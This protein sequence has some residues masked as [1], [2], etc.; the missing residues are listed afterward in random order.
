MTPPLR[1]PMPCGRQALPRGGNRIS[2]RA[3]PRAWWRTS[4]RSSRC[5]RRCRFTPAVSACSRA[6]TARK[7]ATSGS[8]SS[9][10]DSCTRRVIS[11]SASLPRAGSRRTTNTSTGTR[12]RLS[13]PKPSTASLAWCSCRWRIDRCSCRSG[14][15]G[16][17]ACACCCSTRISSRTRLGIASCPRGSTAGAAKRAFSRKSCSASV[18]CSR[19]ARSVSTP[20]VWHLNEGHAAFVILQRLRDLLASG[21][22]WEDALAEVRRTT[23]FTTH[24]PVPAGHDAF[25]FHMVEQHLSSSWGSMNGHGERFLALGHHDSGSGAAFNMT[26]LAMRSAGAINA[27]SKL[28]GSVTRDMFAPLWPDVD[29][30]DRPVRAITNGVHVPT[31]VAAD[32]AALFERHLSP[33]WREQYED[34][35]FWSRIL[36]IP[37]EEIWEV[38]G[39]LRAHLFQFIRERARQRWTNDQAGAARVVASGAMLDPTALTIGFARRFTGYKRPDLVFRDIDRLLRL[40]GRRRSSGAI[41]V[42]RQGASGRRSR[43]ASS[44]ARL[45]PGPRSPDGRPH[46]VRRRLRPARRRTCSCRDATCG[47][48]HR[49]SR[50]KPAAPAA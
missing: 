4:P 29:A 25:P 19:C 38:R 31:W 30:A 39:R 15:C 11:G 37:D 17:A 3:R 40:V 26:A 7:R 24:T 21:R 49:A 12:R 18:A 32:L 9:A 14:S 44:A 35:G 48:T 6:I 41:R 8:P 28:H 42:R 2:V 45:S 34:P 20:A 36:E 1:P 13:A 23:V 46:R 5:T 10:W 43:Q 33:A 22:T 27:V 50:S 16:W 47:S